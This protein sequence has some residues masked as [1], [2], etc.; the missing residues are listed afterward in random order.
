MPNSLSLTPH[1]RPLLLYRLRTRL[2]TSLLFPF[3]THQA[4]CP[5]SCLFLLS[6]PSP[7]TS[8]LRRLLFPPS[9]HHTPLGQG[10]E[11]APWPPQ[12]GLGIRDLARIYVR[13]WGSG[14]REHIPYYAV[15]T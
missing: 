12:W 5:N 8:K 14:K 2:Q 6:S 1:S 15:G 13:L 11:A 9:F 7:C 10:A 4:P 3:L